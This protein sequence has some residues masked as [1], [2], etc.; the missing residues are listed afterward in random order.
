ML[1]EII[2]KIVQAQS[3]LFKENFIQGKHVCQIQD[4]RDEDKAPG[5]N[6]PYSIMVR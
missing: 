5:D 6:F 1:I 2:Q 3:V 4:C